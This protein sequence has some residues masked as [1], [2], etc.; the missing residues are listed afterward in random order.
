[1]ERKASPLVARAVDEMVAEPD[2]RFSGGV[3]ERLLALLSEVH[4]SADTMLIVIR[5]TSDALI[6][7]VW[8]SG[9]DLEA[10]ARTLIRAA[11]HAAETTGLSVIRAAMAAAR[12]ILEAAEEIGIIAERRIGRVL[13][14]R[15]CRTAAPLS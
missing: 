10:A 7:R 9:G 11:I 6:R 8:E 14:G 1:M 13:N 12:G 4:P 3:W 2:D 15:M 5:E